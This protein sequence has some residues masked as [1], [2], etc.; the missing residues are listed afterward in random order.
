MKE[1]K[2]RVWCLIFS[3][4]SLDLETFYGRAFFAVDNGCLHEMITLQVQGGMSERG[5]EVV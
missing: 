1:E 3:V 2:A 5:R 4:G